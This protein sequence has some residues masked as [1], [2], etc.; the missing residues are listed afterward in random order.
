VVDV[1]ERLGAFEATLI[2][3]RMLVDHG[4]MVPT[5][6]GSHPS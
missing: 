1:L 4:G 6:A 2:R 3:F 5:G